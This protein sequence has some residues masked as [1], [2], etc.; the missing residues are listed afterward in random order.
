TQQKVDT[1]SATLGDDALSTS[2]TA[3]IIGILLVMVVMI[4][5]YRLNG[6]VASWA[7]CIYII[8]LFL[9]LAVIPGIQLTLPGIA[10]VVL[11]IGM[12]VDANVVIFERIK[13]EVKGGRPLIHAVRIGFKNAMSA[14]LDANITTIIAAVVLLIFGTGSVRGFAITLLLGVLTS[15][16]TA[17]VV[18]RFLLTNACRLVK[19]PALFLCA[20]KA[21]AE[22]EVQ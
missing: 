10:G 6:V 5:R 14:V 16:L 20:P 17:I 15:M 8:V 7:L 21:Q 13:E 12:A 1:V 4:I 2:V 11:G 22:K 19:N 9:L 18:S 3:A